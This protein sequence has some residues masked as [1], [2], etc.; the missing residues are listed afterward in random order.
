MKIIGSKLGLGLSLWLRLGPNLLVPLTLI[1]THTGN[2][3]CDDFT[4]K[5]ATIVGNSNSIFLLPFVI[6][7]FKNCHSTASGGFNVLK[8]FISKLGYF[9]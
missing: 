3:V 9:S 6:I 2:H 7:W 8:L 5:L 1:L 4:G